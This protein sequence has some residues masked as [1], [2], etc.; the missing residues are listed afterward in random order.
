MD[1]ARQ[2]DRV[3]ITQDKDFGELVFV[4][5]RQHGPLVRVVELSVVEQVQAIGELLEQHKHELMGQV[6][7]TITRGRIRIRRRTN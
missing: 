2:E 6:L 3:L 5:N 1:V 7:V 4:Q